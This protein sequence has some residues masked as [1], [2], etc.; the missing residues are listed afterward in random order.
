MAMLD[1]TNPIH[2]GANSEDEDPYEEA[3]A[4]TRR[5]W[6]DLDAQQAMDEAEQQSLADAETDYAT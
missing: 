4:A 5:L 1:L 3:D 2:S 6:E